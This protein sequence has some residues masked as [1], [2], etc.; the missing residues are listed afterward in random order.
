MFY[1]KNK[2]SKAF[3]VSTAFIIFLKTE[4]MQKNWNKTKQAKQNNKKPH[5]E[6]DSKVLTSAHKSQ[7]I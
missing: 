1:I 4:D 5:T 2:D 3:T 7:E 6:T